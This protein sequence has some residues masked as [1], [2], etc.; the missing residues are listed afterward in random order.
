MFLSWERLI[1]VAETK[2]QIFWNSREID[3]QCLERQA[4]EQAKQIGIQN[5]DY[6]Q[7]LNS[8]LQGLPEVAA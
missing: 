1:D 7:P 3:G 4:G 2:N 5:N 6:V 8:Y